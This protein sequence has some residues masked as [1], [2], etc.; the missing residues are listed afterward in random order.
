MR[1]SCRVRALIRRSRDV[2]QRDDILVWIDL[3]MTGLDPKTCGIV[4]LAMILTDRM[5]T[6]L[7]PPLEL[8]IWQ[9]EEVLARMSPFV[10]QM[11]EESGLLPQIRKSELDLEDAERQVLEILAPI[12]AYRTA[13]L[14]GNSVWQD[15]RFLTEFM[16]AFD[17]Y[18]HYRLIDVSTL[19]E[20]AFW[21]YK[22]RYEKPKAGKHTALFDI[23]Q[24]IAELKYLRQQ[25][26]K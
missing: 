16:P 9:P 12:A 11:H 19:K 22:A 10:R 8:T 6:E 23:R 26:M 20:L 15:R 24:S 18:L 1:E 7:A 21:W 5:L 17:N 13:C 2:T 3:E 4:Q 25:V 14:A